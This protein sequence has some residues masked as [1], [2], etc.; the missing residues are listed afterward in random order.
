MTTTNVR[1]S[2][3]LH[4][5]VRLSN[6]YA[7]LA[8]PQKICHSHQTL[9]PKRLTKTILRFGSA[10]AADMKVHN[11]SKPNIPADPRPA[12]GPSAPAVCSARFEPAN[13][14]AVTPCSLPVGHDGQ[15]E[16]RCL[17]SVCTWP[18]GVTSERE[19]NEPN[20]SIDAPPG[21]PAE[22]GSVQ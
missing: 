20:K 9:L 15:H 19:I 1:E 11:T 13:G 7:V 22:G 6:L 14:E 5:I 16:G 3:E 8:E 2:A 4:P 21:A 17:G 10:K 12:S 18:Q